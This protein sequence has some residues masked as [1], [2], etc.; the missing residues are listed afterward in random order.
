MTKLQKIEQL[1]AD[2]PEDDH[3][4]TASTLIGMV[5]ALRDMIPV[6]CPCC[7]QTEKCAD[8]CTFGDDDPQGEEEMECRR[9]LLRNIGVM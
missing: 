2:Y 5:K 6:E 3:Y 4:G 8:G 7:E 1:L 9:E